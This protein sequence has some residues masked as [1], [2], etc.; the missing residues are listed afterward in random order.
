MPHVILE[1]ATE[2]EQT[3]NIHTLVDAAFAATERSGLFETID[4][5]VR[6]QSFQAYTTGGTPQL[7]VHAE[8]KLL[9]GRSEAQKKALA[10]GVLESLKTTLPPTIAISVE[11]N[12]LDRAS[13]SKRA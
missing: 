1:Y 13:Y 4:I 7:F 5:K 9:S 3:V 6:A 12:D 8:I 2:L 10:Q 11:T